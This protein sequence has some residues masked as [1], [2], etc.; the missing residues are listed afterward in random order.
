MP[1][2]AFVLSA[3]LC[4]GV[5]V[6]DSSRQGLSLAG[7]IICSLELTAGE[8]ALFKWAA[9]LRWQRGGS[10]MMMLCCLLM[11]RVT[12]LVKSTLTPHFAVWMELGVRTA[13]WLSAESTHWWKQVLSKCAAPNMFRFQSTL[14]PPDVFEVKVALIWSYPQ[15]LFPLKTDVLIWVNCSALMV[16]HRRM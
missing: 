14:R 13:L 10:Y 5:L 6:V 7:V 12:D 9:D 2:S 4:M 8:F 3:P 1:P 16:F 15:C 11:C